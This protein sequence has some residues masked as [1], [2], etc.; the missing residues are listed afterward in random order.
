MSDDIIKDIID[1]IRNRRGL[2]DKYKPLI[3]KHEKLKA[4]YEKLKADYEELIDAYKKLEGKYEELTNNSLQP[5]DCDVN[6]DFTELQAFSVERVFDGTER[7]IIG[8]IFEGNIKEWFLY[9]SRQHHNELV[10]KFRK[11]EKMKKNT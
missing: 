1:G 6:I 10:D 7:T 4:D 8:Y 2:K 11:Y 9:I 5:D 3:T